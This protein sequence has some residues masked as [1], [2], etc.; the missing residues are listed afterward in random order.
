M[1]RCSMWIPTE[2]TN[3]LTR[4]RIEPPHA[5]TVEASSKVGIGENLHSKQQASGQQINHQQL[6]PLLD[7]AT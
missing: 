4:Y 1:D 5:G 7:Q 2:S 3:Q 6:L